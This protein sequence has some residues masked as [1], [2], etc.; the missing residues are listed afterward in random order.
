MKKGQGIS[1][2]VIVVA[3][4]ALLVLAVLAVI[5]LGRSNI[6]VKESVNCESQGGQCVV[7]ECP[8]SLG[9]YPAWAC[10]KTAGG[11]QQTCCAIPR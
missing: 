11:A 2:N 5:F 3:A 4:V 6:F 8:Q 7:G 1:I 9:P 10:P